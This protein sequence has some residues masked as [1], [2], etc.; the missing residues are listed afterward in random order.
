MVGS[1]GFEAGFVVFVDPKL[2]TSRLETHKQHRKLFLHEE[3]LP[4][5]THE[6][7]PPL[8]TREKNLPGGF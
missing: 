3:N 8:A 7:E 6:E 2:Y 1:R 4:P 5:S